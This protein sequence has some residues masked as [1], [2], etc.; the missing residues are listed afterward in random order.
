[1]KSP[2]MPSSKPANPQPTPWA[3]TRGLCGCGD[4][5]PSS[6][7]V[8]PAQAGSSTAYRRGSIRAWLRAY[9]DWPKLADSGPS[10]RE[11]GPSHIEVVLK[12]SKSARHLRRWPADI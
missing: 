9:S 10:L 5:L 6:A 12:W 4:P 8:W 1:M 11:M 7:N 2:R 3:A